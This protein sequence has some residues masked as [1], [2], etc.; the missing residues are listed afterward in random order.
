MSEAD[1][2]I[3]DVGEVGHVA[4]EGGEVVGTELTEVGVAAGPRQH[5]H[6]LH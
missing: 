4:V 6:Q 1:A 3:A 2:S 5:G